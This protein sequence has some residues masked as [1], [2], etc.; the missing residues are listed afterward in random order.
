MNYKNTINYQEIYED[1]LTPGL[2]QNLKHKDRFFDLSNHERRFVEEL[3][4]LGY[5]RAVTDL[6]DVNVLEDTAA[7]AGEMGTQLYNFAN[8]LQAYLSEAKQNNEDDT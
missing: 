5:Q 6:L 2:T 7:L 1:E 4:D 8:M 3:V